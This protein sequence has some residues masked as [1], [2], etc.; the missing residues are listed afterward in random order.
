HEFEKFALEKIG[1]GE[2]AQAYGHGLYFAEKEGTAKAY[3]DA[4]SRGSTTTS[5]G[6]RYWLEQA[7]GNVEE[8]VKQ[9]RAYAPPSRETDAIVDYLLHPPGHMYEVHIKAD[10]EHFLDWDK[11]LNEQSPPV[12]EALR[13]LGFKSPSE[14]LRRNYEDAIRLAAKTPEDA[15]KAIRIAREMMAGQLPLP[16]QYAHQHWESLEKYAPGVNHDA[17][18]DIVATPGESGEAIYDALRVPRT[19]RGND[20]AAARALREAGIKGIK[21]LDQGSRAAG[22]GS[23]NYV[24]FDDALIDILRKYGL[25]PPVVGGTIALSH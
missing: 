20:E 21:Y 9:L 6:A 3:R 17:I 12:Q 18:H 5:D 4:L 16:G 11:P 25:L 14:P 7:G 2:G 24:V 1:T 22:E 8:A 19:S 23:R 10:P 15:E 13:R